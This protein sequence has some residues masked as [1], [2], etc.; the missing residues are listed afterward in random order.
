M[1]YRG[2]LYI[3]ELITIGVRIHLHLMDLVLPLAFS[4]VFIMH[5]NG[6]SKSIAITQVHM[7]DQ[8]KYR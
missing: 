7:V 3:V 1:I 5:I 6:L 4:C 2:K 8:T